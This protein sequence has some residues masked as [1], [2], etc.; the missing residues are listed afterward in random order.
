MLISNIGTNHI[1]ALRSIKQPYLL[2]W[3]LIPS[4]NQIAYYQECNL[5]LFKPWRKKGG[6]IVMI[7][8]SF[9]ELGE[10]IEQC[11]YMMNQGDVSKAKVIMAQSQQTVY[12][13]D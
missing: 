11:V 4:H 12:P 8:N 7:I 9:D 6:G 13:G 10:V 2:Y 1:S 5:P 3:Q